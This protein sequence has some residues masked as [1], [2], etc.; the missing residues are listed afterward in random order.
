[1]GNIEKGG[2]MGNAVEQS[3]EMLRD[4]LVG[5]KEEGLCVEGKIY[6]CLQPLIILRNYL[7]SNNVSC[8]L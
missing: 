6:D 2:F 1:M 3:R 8:R 7:S 4:I 5:A